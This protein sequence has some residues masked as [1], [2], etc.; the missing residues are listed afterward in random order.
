MLVQSCS[1]KKTMEKQ[2]KLY[3][4]VELKKIEFSVLDSVGS[5]SIMYPAKFGDDLKTKELQRLYFDC[6]YE[7]LDSDIDKFNKCIEEQFISNLFD[8]EDDADV[9]VKYNLISKV[10]D[11]YNEC[12]VLVFCK[13][14]R[15]SRNDII[16]M[17]R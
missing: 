15:I 8:S 13:E 10:T 4:K 6:I 5:V 17:D 1:N 12:D 16:T 11:I 2:D 3:G 7:S 9:N 14:E